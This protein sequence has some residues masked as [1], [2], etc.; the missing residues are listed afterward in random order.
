[1]KRRAILIHPP[2]TQS[3]V[4]KG[5]WVREKLKEDRLKEVC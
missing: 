2:D 5:E 3:L 1:M 4:K